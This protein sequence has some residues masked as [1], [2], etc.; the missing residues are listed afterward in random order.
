MRSRWCG[1]ALG[2]A[3]G[4]EREPHRGQELNLHLFNAARESRVVLV[5]VVCFSGRVR[6][7]DDSHPLSRA[8]VV[9][10]S[11]SALFSS[12]VVRGRVPCNVYIVFC[13]IQGVDLPNKQFLV[14]FSR[15]S[16]GAGIVA[17]WSIRRVCFEECC[18]CCVP[19]ACVCKLMC[20]AGR[21]SFQCCGLL[22]DFG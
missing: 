20:E 16:K 14:G 21:G 2:G 13:L 9:D 18:H 22:C 5:W 6:K 15:R 8:W 7:R 17:E 1:R 12:S 10:F 4:E 19:R 11:R 3:I